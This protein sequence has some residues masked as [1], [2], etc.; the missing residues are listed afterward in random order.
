MPAS[1]IMSPTR[2]CGDA[3]TFYDGS[4][5]I[6]DE[7]AG[8]IRFTID[9]SGNTTVGWGLMVVL[10][11]V[12]RP[13]ASRS[14]PLYRHCRLLYFLLGGGFI[15][16]AGNLSVGQINSNGDIYTNSIH[17]A[18][19]AYVQGVVQFSR[20]NQHVL[21]GRCRLY[22]RRLR[23]WS[24]GYFVANQGA[25]VSNGDL[26]VYGNSWIRGGGIYALD[27]GIV[28]GPCWCRHRRQHPDEAVAACRA[29]AI[30]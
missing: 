25:Q 22:A 8:Q 24:Q 26:N 1:A 30:S 17:T 3:G 19:H 9:T 6:A 13:F 7:S 27:A 21:V 28:V 18:Y 5:R 20:G 4:Y 12:L 29:A 10:P 11:T 15:G 2:G 14:K 16:I 23:F